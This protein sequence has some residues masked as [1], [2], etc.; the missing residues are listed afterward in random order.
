MDDIQKRL[1]FAYPLAVEAGLTTLEYF[2]QKNYEVER[3]GDNSPVTMADRNAEKL[4]RE[5]IA[6]AF[7]QDGILGEEFGQ[8]AGTSNYRWILDPIDGTKSFITGVPLYSVLIGVMRDREALVGVIHIP[9]LAESVYAARGAGAWW[10]Q[11]TSSARP[12]RVSTRSLA[13][14]VFV[15]S[16][17]DGFGKGGRK[18]AYRRLEDEAYITRTWG[19]GYGY[20]LVATGRAEVMVD[21]V[22]NL[23]DAAPLQPI[24]E[25]AGGGFTDWQGEAC[26]DHNEGVGCNLQVQEE[27]LAITKGVE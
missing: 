8:Q 10:R 13:S 26:V 1:E 12:A 9:A 22:M 3:K 7:P 18:Q 27:V 5:R 21:P 25:E 4:M 14:G 24:L 17:V 2:Q 23:W 19:D 20:L 16:Q 15:N 6:D 11:G